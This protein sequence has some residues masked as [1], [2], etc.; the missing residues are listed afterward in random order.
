M[1]DRVVDTLCQC[2][3]DV[4]SVSVL[5]LGRVNV[6]KFVEKVCGKSLFFVFLTKGVRVGHCAQVS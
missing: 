1:S 3:V 2:S 5:K 6:E 4:Q